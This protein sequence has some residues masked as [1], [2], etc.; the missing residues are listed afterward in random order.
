MLEG[1]GPACRW[2]SSM[3]TSGPDRILP[4]RTTDGSPCRCSGS[5]SSSTTT[6]CSPCSRSVAKPSDCTGTAFLRETRAPSGGPLVGRSGLVARVQTPADLPPCRS[7]GGFGGLRLARAARHLDRWA[8]TCHEA[9][10]H[11]CD[12]RGMADRPPPVAVV[13]P[14]RQRPGPKP[15]AV[16]R[17]RDYVA[18]LAGRG[19]V[20]PPES[21]GELRVVPDPRPRGRGRGAVVHR[22]VRRV[23]AD[24]GGRLPQRD[25]GPGSGGRPDRGCVRPG[26]RG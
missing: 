19:L 13:G 1:P 23:P 25:A 4:G 15:L 9:P 8:A 24:T 5:S 14:D 22:T 7:A 16:G 3:R 10:R 20:P 18:S 26:P 21:G 12:G 11:C 17:S 6:G 2:R